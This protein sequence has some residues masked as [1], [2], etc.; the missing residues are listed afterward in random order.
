MVIVV[1]TVVVRLVG[2]TG[3]S[4]VAL[5]VEDVERAGQLAEPHARSVGQQPPPRLAGQERK[6]AEHVGERV[7]EDVMVLVIVTVETSG[8]SGVTL[9]IEVVGEVVDEVVVG[10]VGCKGVTVV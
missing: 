3:G 2:R 10:E 6:P 7:A 1:S 8:T 5:D 4:G 9:E